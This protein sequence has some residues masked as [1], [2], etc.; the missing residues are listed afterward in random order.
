MGCEIKSVQCMTGRPVGVIEE[1]LEDVA[2]MAMEYENGSYGSIHAAYTKPSVLGPQGY[3]SALVYRGLEGWANW[4]PVGD[5]KMEVFSAI[6]EWSGSPERIFEYSLPAFAG[7]GKVKW[8]HTWLMHFIEAIRD[9]KPT[10]LTVEDGLKILQSIDAAYESAETG[11]RVEVN[12]D[13]G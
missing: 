12:Y 11:K 3:D 10:Y 8:M 6:P 2:I 1:P 13:I 4:A 7:Y 5:H 9:D